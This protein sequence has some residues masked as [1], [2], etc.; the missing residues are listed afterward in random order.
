MTL[1][2]HD[3]QLDGCAA[4]GDLPLSLLC[5]KALTHGGVVTSAQVF[6]VLNADVI[7]MDKAALEK[8]KSTY[9]A[10]AAEEAAAEAAAAGEAA[11]EETAAEPA[12]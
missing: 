2:Q 10:A 1:Q 4:I 12:Q 7:V 3:Q 11:A 5:V 8:V 6:D 9:A